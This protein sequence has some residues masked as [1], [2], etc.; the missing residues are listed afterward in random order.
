MKKKTDFERWKEWFKVND[1]ESFY[2][3]NDEILL[4]VYKS[5]YKS[6]WPKM[7]P[8]MNAK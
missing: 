8:K 7:F 3:F 1:P 2:I 5:D 4:E 6:W